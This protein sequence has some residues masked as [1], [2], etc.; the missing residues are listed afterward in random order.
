MVSDFGHPRTR[1]EGGVKKGQ[2]FVDV[3]YGWPLS[4]LACCVHLMLGLCNLFFTACSKF[5]LYF[6]KISAFEDQI[7]MP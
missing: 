3:L 5:Q 6:L 7:L 4:T 1:G 2:I